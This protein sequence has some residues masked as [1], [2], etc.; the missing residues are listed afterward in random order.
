MC[1]KNNKSY[2]EE[3]WLLSYPLL[4]H[5]YNFIKMCIYNK[6]SQKPNLYSSLSFLNFTAR[7]LCMFREVLF[8]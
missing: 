3:N 1:W 6:V 8:P 4:G 7:V 2:V 5:F